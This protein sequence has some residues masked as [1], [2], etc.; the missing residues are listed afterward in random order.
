MKAVN[1]VLVKSLDDYVKQVLPTIQTNGAWTWCVRENSTYLDC[2]VAE[3]ANE[4]NITIAAYNPAASPMD[5]VSIILKSPNYTVQTYNHSTGSW[6][7]AG[8]DRAAII[9]ENETLS[10]GFAINSCILHVSYQIDGH[11][12]GLLQLTYDNSSNLNVP[13][14]FAQTATFSSDYETVT[15]NGYD[16]NLGHHL[17][18]AKKNYQQSFNVYAD[19]RYWP[20]FGNDDF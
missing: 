13:G 20:G 16:N 5:V 18:I 7:S 9:C 8:T 12:V 6:I 10:N 15:L 19:L 3:Q 17:T 1:S 11:Q 14:N 4:A 2:P